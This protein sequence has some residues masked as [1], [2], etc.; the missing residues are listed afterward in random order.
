MKSIVKMRECS[1]LCQYYSPF[2]GFGLGKGFGFGFGTGVPK[3][4]I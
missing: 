2:E 4:E 3:N 1:I